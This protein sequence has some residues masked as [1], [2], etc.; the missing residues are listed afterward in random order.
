MTDLERLCEAKGVT[1]EVKYGV[2]GK[3]HISA[4]N[5]YGSVDSNPYTV[6]LKYGSKRLTVPF[7][8]G[9][10]IKRDPTPADV[11][12][13]LCTDAR[14]GLMTFEEFCS[15]FGYD[16]DSRKAE[17]TWKACEKL[18]PRLVKFLGEELLEELS[19]AEH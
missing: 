10:G 18:A 1:A 5:D 8:Q 14:A 15:D 9:R 19:N 17:K 2:Y 6:T 11:L 4:W 13:C 16:P 7:F 12:Y 3:E